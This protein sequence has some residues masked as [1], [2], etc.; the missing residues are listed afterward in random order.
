M[1]GAA[2]GL[3]FRLLQP[4]RSSDN[5]AA[6]SGKKESPR[7]T[8]YAAWPERTQS[9]QTGAEAEAHP[10][11]P[12]LRRLSAHRGLRLSAT[13]RRKPPVRARTGPKGHGKPPPPPPPPPPLL[14]AAAAILRRLRRLC[15]FPP[16]TVYL[17]RW[18]RAP[19]RPTVSLITPA[20]DFVSV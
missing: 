13:W 15:L 2:E 6:D 14:S 18:P 11:F 4:T 17:R 19:P 8:C 20:V 3:G 7:A 9:L 1:E 16:S 5:N 10:H 12:A